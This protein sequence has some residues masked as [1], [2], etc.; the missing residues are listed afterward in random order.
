MKEFE[1]AIIHSGFAAGPV[2][3]ADLSRVKTDPSADQ[4][5]SFNPEHEMTLYNRAVDSLDRELA[6]AAE[7]ADR[8]SRDIYETE[9][10]L[11]KDNVFSETVRELITEKNM[12]VNTAVEHAGNVLAQKLAGTE[13]AY[14]R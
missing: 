12:N 4:N 5:E 3:D 10:L 2:F 14:I 9:R 13:N 1:L 6:S 7:K 8:N 11:L